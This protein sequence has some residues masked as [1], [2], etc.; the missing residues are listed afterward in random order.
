M[1][2]VAPGIVNNAE[3]TETLAG[4][5]QRPALVSVPEFALKLL[6]GRCRKSCCEPARE[7]RVALE[8]GYQFKFADLKSALSNLLT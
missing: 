8:T 6:F 3:Y 4:V 2:G 1:N 7:A 5:L